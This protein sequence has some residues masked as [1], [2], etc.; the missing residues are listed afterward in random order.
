MVDYRYNRCGVFSR[1]RSFRVPVEKIQSERGDGCM[2]NVDE[3][4][5]VDTEA[6]K[7][8]YEDVD[9]TD[10]FM[11]SY[12]MRQPEICIE[13]LEYLFPGHKIRTVKYVRTDDTEESAENV[14][15][16]SQK[17]L[18][19]IFGKKGVRLDV[20]L[21][22][23]K[24]VYNVEMQTEQQKFLPKRSRYY[25]AQIDINLL[26]RG[27]NYDQLKPSYVIFICKF[28]PFGK[29]KYRYT[30]RNLCEEVDGLVLNDEAYKVFF[31]TVG[32]EGEISENLRELLRYMNNTKDYP[33]AETKYDLIRKIDDAVGI[34]KKDDEWRRAYMTYQIHQRDAELRGAENK[35]RESALNMYN[36]GI[37]I[38]KIAQYLGCAV[39]TVKKWLSMMPA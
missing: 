38:E 29:G 34:A 24:T 27:E 39:D 19:E 2:S 4:Q 18:A 9:I 8:N 1:K 7:K 32:T 37:K 26:E 20:Y 22:D 6:G 12:I 3:A 16:D 13:L 5:D 35:A 15:A 36:D 23:G 11:F 25:Q 14:R 28:D 21:D 33:V 10:D 30:F 17:T 31:S